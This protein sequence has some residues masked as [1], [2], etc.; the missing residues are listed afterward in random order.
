MPARKKNERVRIT[1]R[2]SGNLFA[3]VKMG[4][5]SGTNDRLLE[6]LR[7]QMPNL[8]VD[9]I[10]IGDLKAIKRTDAVR[11]LYAV[12]HDYGLSSC[13]EKSRVSS[14]LIRT[15]YCFKKIREHLLRRLSQKKYVF[16]FQTQSLFDASILNTPHFLYTDH[17]HL[18]N[19]TYPGERQT[20]MASAEWIRLERLM[21]HNARLNFAMSAHVTRS[22]VEHYGCLP[23]R[24]KCVYAGGNI[25][26]AIGEDLGLERFARKNI[27]FV[28]IDW[29]RKGG[30]TLLAAFREVRRSHP[31]ATLTIVGCAPKVSMPGC[32]VVGR[33]QF[34]EVAKFYQAATVFC[35]PSTV[36]PFGIVFLEAFA[37]GL[38]IV[39]T[40]IGAIPEFVEHG[41]SG[42]LV[43]CNDA[44]QLAIRLNELLRDPARCAAFGA[45]GQALVQE[46][47]SWRATA[48]RLAVHID[49]CIRLDARAVRLRESRP[50]SDADLAGTPYAVTDAP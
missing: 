27:L 22:L 47:Y 35:L 33:V 11:L 3:F 6:Q 5:F 36:E 31:T 25:A 42:Y 39:A 18:L 26:P 23:S 46:R 48:E 19:S 13:L 10:D 28:G 15:V 1:M 30:P 43:D 12:A 41:R 24:I 34:A 4:D 8:D 17:T 40:N 32:H 16:T 44:T 50:P 49:C 45:R 29:E 21:Y 7:L 20:P 14:R 38:P 37:H 2:A 9:V